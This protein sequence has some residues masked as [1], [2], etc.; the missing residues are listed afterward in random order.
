MNVSVNLGSGKQFEGKIT[1]INSKV[2]QSTRNVLVQVTIPNE[3]YQLYPGMYGLVKVWL[4]ANRNAVVVPQT[5]ISYSLSG[6]YVFVVK[7]EGKSKNKPDLHAYR[8]YVKVGERRDNEASIVDGLETGDRIVT[9]GQ[10]KLQN[11][12]RILIDNS[13]E[14]S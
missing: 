5:A 1:A 9:S 3:K 12:T 10:L 6:D 13:I 14:L 2:E 4:K 8:K 7:D 11:G